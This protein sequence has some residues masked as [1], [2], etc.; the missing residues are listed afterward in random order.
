MGSPNSSKI[1]ETVPYNGGFVYCMVLNAV[2]GSFFFG[3]VM[4]LFNTAQDYITEVVYP[5]ISSAVTYLMTSFVPLGAGAGAYL[6][7]GV[8]QSLGRRKAMLL[9]DLISIVGTLIQ[10]LPSPYLLLAGRLISG[11]CV[12]LNSTLVPQYI[13]EVAPLKVKGVAGTSFQVFLNI[14]ILVSYLIGNGLPDN[15]KTGDEP[16]FFWKIMFGL[17]LITCLIRVIGLLTFFRYDTP[18]YCVM[19][20][21]EDEASSMLLRIYP[22]DYA[23]EQLIW[24]RREKEAETGSTETNTNSML[25]R[26]NK[27]R[28]RSGVLLSMFQQLCGI[29]AIIFYSKSIFTNTSGADKAQLYTIIV[30]VVNLCAT[31]TASFLIDKAG[32]KFLVV[33]GSVFMGVVLTVFAI[34]GII[35]STSAILS[36]LIFVYVVGFGLSLGPVVWPYIAEILHDGGVN[37]SVLSNWSIAFIVAQTFPYMADFLG[38]STSFLVFAAFSFISAFVCGYTIPET[39]G[40]SDAQIKQL[41]ESFSE[42]MDDTEVALKK[43]QY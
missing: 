21:K 15:F 6:A 18:R 37:I 17:P 25:K 39:K 12:G 22:K 23:N 20:D 40:K 10:I 30:G 41:F 34:V 33:F 35:D 42:N 27:R 31:I 32:R 16:V 19:N 5:D 38:N 14:G 28:F 4:G 9:T 26:A 3:Y 2:M 36:Y 29:N 24:I 11:F 8:S 1:E 7:G 13:S 43:N